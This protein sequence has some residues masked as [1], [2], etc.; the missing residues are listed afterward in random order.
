[1][2]TTNARFDD[3]ERPTLPH[4]EK[5]PIVR[6]GTRTRS[7]TR[8]KVTPPPLPSIDFEEEIE[9]EVE[10]DADAEPEIPVDWEPP[11]L[12]PSASVR[13]RERTKRR[14]AKSARWK[15][16]ALVLLAVADLALA[17]A[18][19]VTQRAHA[20][21]TAAP[22]VVAP[23][24]PAPAPADIEPDPQ[25]AAI[26]ENMGLLRTDEMRPGH[27][28]FVGGRTV[29]ETPEPILVKCG[30]TS[31]KVGSAGQARTIDV[32]CGGEV[33]VW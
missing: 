12:S 4:S 16:V 28:I 1:M 8:A 10:A 33:R 29:G 15:V 20:V 23:P 6:E 9:V 26:P 21:T 7:G 25:T 31:I 19:F 11:I 3:D 24:V 2:P 27:R 13:G 17:R 5:I 18:L 22:P 14:R 30:S 32:P